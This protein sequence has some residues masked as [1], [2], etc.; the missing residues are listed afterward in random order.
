LSITQIHTDK[1]KTVSEI[2]AI[3]AL[4]LLTIDTTN[5]LISSG[6][7]GFLPLTDQ[8]SGIYLG[9]PSVIIFFLSFGFAFKIKTRL[10]TALLIAGGSLLAVSKI[11]EPIMG[12]NLYLVLV[13][14]YLYYSLIV[15]GF[16]ILGLGIFRVIRKQKDNP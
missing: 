14:P 15:I 8:Q 5:T 12:S 9:L 2:L 4:T 7:Y 1:R 16:V 3:I 10:T 11:V 13:L 6:R